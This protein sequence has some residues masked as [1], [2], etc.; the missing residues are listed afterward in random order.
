MSS[1]ENDKSGG[2]EGRQGYKNVETLDEKM[3]NLSISSGSHNY[4]LKDRERVLKIIKM[5]NDRKTNKNR[6][7]F[8][9]IELCHIKTKYE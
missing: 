1:I 9:R 3:N 7:H 2:Q 8:L 5:L 4:T 6:K